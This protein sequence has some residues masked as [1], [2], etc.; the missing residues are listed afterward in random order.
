MT[1]RALRPGLPV[2][3]LGGWGWGDWKTACLLPGTLLF[4]VRKTRMSAWKRLLI[5]SVP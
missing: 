4:V 1:R 2:L 3:G 5:R